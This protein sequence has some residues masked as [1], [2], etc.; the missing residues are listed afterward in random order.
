MFT[1][2]GSP[3][4]V[5]PDLVV[6]VPRSR[7]S[8]RGFVRSCILLASF[9]YYTSILVTL[10]TLLSFQRLKYFKNQMFWWLDRFLFF[11]KCTSQSTPTHTVLTKGREMKIFSIFFLKIDKKL[12][13][14][15]L[16]LIWLTL[17]CLPVAIWKRNKTGY[18]QVQDFWTR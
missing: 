9:F 11:K 17:Q 1:R 15:L 6:A 8:V 3:K 16:L 4:S 12:D 2:S 13:L 14:F 10:R 5:H 7:T 18:D